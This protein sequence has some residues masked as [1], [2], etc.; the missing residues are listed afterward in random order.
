MRTLNLSAAFI[1]L[2]I[3]A[4]AGVAPAS[5]EQEVTIDVP[6][7]VTNLMDEVYSL[8]VRCFVTK[9]DLTDTLGISIAFVDVNKGAAQETISV[10]VTPNQGMNFAAAENYRCLLMVMAPGGQYVPSAEAAQGDEDD[11]RRA[12]PGEPFTSEV[13]GPLSPEIVQIFQGAEAFSSSN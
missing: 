7:D 8:Q 3:A 5:A 13:S 6:I 10:V 2:A 11:F 1:A 12:D 9:A 4:S